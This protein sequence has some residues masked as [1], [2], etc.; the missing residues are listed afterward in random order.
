[1]TDGQIFQL[2]G[3][4]YFLVGLGLLLNPK[5]YKKAFKGFVKHKTML[6]VSSL[7]AL[8]VGFLIVCFHNFWLFDWPIIITI[9][10]WLALVK[11]IMILI[12]PEFFMKIAGHFIKKD[13]TGWA[14]IVTILGVF[15][16]SLSYFI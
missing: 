11:G 7:F 3:L 1:M 2:I 13:F 5:Y 16:F 12:M 14:I 9:I 15:L 4:I 6:F 8:I 10:G